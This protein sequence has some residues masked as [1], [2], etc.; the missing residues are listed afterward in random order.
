M[1]D[2]AGL[3]PAR[4][5][6]TARNGQPAALVGNPIRQGVQVDPL[7]VAAEDAPYFWKQGDAE[8]TRR[9]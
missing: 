4:I 2:R 1:E 7:P 9:R 3:I 6:E 5:P 8:S